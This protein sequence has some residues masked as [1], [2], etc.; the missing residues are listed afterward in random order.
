VPNRYDGPAQ[1][2]ITVVVSEANP[3]LGVSQALALK[4]N[5]ASPAYVEAAVAPAA[6]G[7]PP[8]PAFDVDV[9][10]DK[11][12]ATRARNPQAVA[13]VIGVERYNPGVPA[14]R[15]AR[16][17]AAIFR[18]YLMTSL[19]VPESNIIYLT[20]EAATFGQIRTALEA[21]LPRWVE[22]GRSDVYVYFAGHGAPDMASR[23]PFLVPYDGNPAYPATSCYSLTAAYDA[24]A[25]LGARSVTVC[26]DSCFSGQAG[27]E[28]APTPLLADARPLMITPLHDAVPPGLTVFAAAGGAQ[29][30][31]GFARMKHGLFTYYWL[32][33][34]QGH[35]DADGD[36]QVSVGE[37][38]RYLQ[39]LV[40][41]EARRQNREQTP[42]LLG[43]GAE[44]VLV[45]L[46]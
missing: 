11:P 29:L 45:N 32:K 43:D 2:P 38:Q 17:D 30:S 46:P 18:E 27:R 37:L 5:Q 31:A 23:S 39:P 44:R 42:V 15:F 21:Q 8:E 26:L 33:G 22:K 10:V 12:V 9:D 25:K 1:L 41:Q 14:V 34:L 16:R 19:G 36:R 24:L 3:A 13:L 20:D 4:L 35:A 40:S 6:S 7:P 28:P